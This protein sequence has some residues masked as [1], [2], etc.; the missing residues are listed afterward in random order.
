MQAN[1][2][3][4]SAPKKPAHLSINSDVLRQAKLQKINISEVC[5]RSLVEA[6]KER[7][8][9][10]WQESNKEAIVE[11]RT[12]IEVHGCFADKLRSF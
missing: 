4:Q 1:V 10:E 11:Y 6:L 8:R 7:K 9:L 12:F 3:D 5:E 2:Y